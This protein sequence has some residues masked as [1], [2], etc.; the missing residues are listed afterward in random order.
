[1]ASVITGKVVRLRRLR[2]SDAEFMHRWN[3]DPEYAG[4]YEPYEP[5]TLE[6]LRGWISGGGGSPWYIMENIHGE[7]VG[8]MVA[9]RK[10]DA[11]EVGYRVIP[12]MRGRGYCTE[13]VRDLV[14]HLFRDESV[15][16][17][18]AETNP[19]N[20]ASRRVLERNGFKVHEYKRDA[21]RINGVLMDG[22]V[23]RLTRDDY[24]HSQQ[25]L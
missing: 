25:V 5:V 6:W 14:E 17:V 12:P 18:K 19:G 21:V 7:R 13:A 2:V 15:Q 20:V 24:V 4:K 10:G 22:V 8:Q 23:Y 16:E 1:L 3:N 9:T 11:V